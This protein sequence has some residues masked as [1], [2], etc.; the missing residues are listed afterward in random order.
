MAASAPLLFEQQFLLSV[1]GGAADLGA[2]HLSSADLRE[3]DLTEE[4][5]RK[6]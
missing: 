1:L 3:A 6:S 4:Q 5:L 2:A